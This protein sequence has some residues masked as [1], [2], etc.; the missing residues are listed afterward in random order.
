MNSD[1][2]SLVCFRAMLAS[3]VLRS[4]RLS[5]TGTQALSFKL[6]T[7][8]LVSWGHADRQGTLT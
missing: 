2:D 4:V 1:N 8:S 3:L 5:S 7:S 6:E